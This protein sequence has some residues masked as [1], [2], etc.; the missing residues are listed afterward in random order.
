MDKAINHPSASVGDVHQ[1]GRSLLNAGKKEEAM[2]VFQTNRKLHPGDTFTTYVGLARGY[3][4]VG[5]KKNSV[6]YWELAIKN[7]PEDQKS[8]LAF[9]EGELKKVKEGS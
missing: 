4:A 1:Y 7:L 9:Y 3:S 5:D 2:A 6:K 8:N